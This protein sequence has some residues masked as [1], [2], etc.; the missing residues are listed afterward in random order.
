MA[1][2]ISKLVTGYREHTLRPGHPQ[3]RPDGLVDV[4]AWL[5]EKTLSQIATSEFRDY[6]RFKATLGA[7][8]G[9][10]SLWG[11]KQDN[12]GDLYLR[13]AR[14][15]PDKGLHIIAGSTINY[16]D[17]TDWR[18]VAIIAYLSGTELS[19]H[20]K[21]LVKDGYVN[22]VRTG[23]GEFYPVPEFTLRTNINAAGFTDFRRGNLPMKYHKLVLDVTGERASGEA[24]IQLPPGISGQLRGPRG[25]PLPPPRNR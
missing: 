6:A 19:A 14:I 16:S 25:I 23:G 3:E 11:V 10:V 17:L 24:L 1:N 18:D 20:Y 12:D 21:Q 22:A 8:V 4:T 5:A 9:G 2:D 13:I 7:P 15:Y